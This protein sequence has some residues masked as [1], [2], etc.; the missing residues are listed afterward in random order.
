MPQEVKERHNIM[1]PGDLWELIR[2][3]GRILGKN[4]SEVIEDS[5]K[6]YIKNNGY[7]RAFFK[8]MAA[9]NCPAEENEELTKALD[10]LT[11]EETQPGKQIEL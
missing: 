11:E 2:E 9:P 4:A 5:L 8:L 10:S 7:N 6:S 1:V 3:I